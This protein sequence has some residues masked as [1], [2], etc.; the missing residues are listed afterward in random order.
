MCVCVCVFV[1]AHARARVR[2]V[3]VCV[4]VCVCVCFVTGLLVLLAAWSPCRSRGAAVQ[5][6]LHCCDSCGFLL[7]CLFRL[8]LNELRYEVARRVSSFVLQHLQLRAVCRPP[9]PLA[10]PRAGCLS[11]CLSLSVCLS[12][13]VS[14]SLL[15]MSLC[16]SRSRSLCL[17]V[18]VSLCVSVSPL[19]LMP[20]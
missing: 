9:T 3:H 1:R 5:L 11:Q 19:V 7:V 15:S 6:G 16:L 13:I 18:S 14:V 20:A 12:V 4:C 10:P 17:S 8:G 2:C